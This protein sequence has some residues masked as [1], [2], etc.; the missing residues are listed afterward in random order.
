MPDIPKD[1]RQLARDILAG[2]ISLEDLAREQARRRSGPG[3]PVRPASN[4][5]TSPDARVPAALPMQNRPQAR[6]AARPPQ[7]AQQRRP[8]PQA[9]ARRP[10][11][12][13]QP[14]RGPN[15]V[16]P[17]AA[18]PAAP[19]AAPAAPPQPSRTTPKQD[20]RTSLLA[21]FKNRTTLRQGVLL[22]EILGKPLSLRDE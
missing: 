19:A 3:A 14:P 6:P 4:I 15:F 10:T 13:A 11:A 1:P 9:P 7:Q 20:A 8:A 18:P 22:A 21:S 16:M 2:R 5:P 12:A 17:A